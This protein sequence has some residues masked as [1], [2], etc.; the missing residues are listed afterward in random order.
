M[1]R[2]LEKGSKQVGEEHESEDGTDLEKR[3][4]GVC[5]RLGEY[6]IRGERESRGRKLGRGKL[7]GGL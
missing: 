7:T 4:L 6:W 2:D 1:R 3:V 5:G